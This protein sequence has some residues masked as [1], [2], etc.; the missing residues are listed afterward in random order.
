M[1][2]SLE[3]QKAETKQIQSEM[4]KKIGD[5]KNDAESEIYNKE[6]E[7]VKFRQELIVD[8]FSV[9]EAKIVELFD[10]KLKRT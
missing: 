2:A 9:L 7:F 6:S 1:Y 8:I 4:S 3:L 10:V 5:Y